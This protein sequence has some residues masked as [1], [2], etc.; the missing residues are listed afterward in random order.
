[1]A[2][3]LIR[4]SEAALNYVGTPFKHLGRSISG[5]DCAGLL[6]LAAKDCGYVAKDTPIYGHQPRDGHMQ[7]TLLKHACRIVDRPPQPDDIVVLSFKEDGPGIHVGIITEHPHGIGC[8]H[9]YGHIG[10]V[11]HQR[12]DEKRMKLISAVLEWKHG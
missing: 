7:A 10:R 11:V 8:V 1:M 3:P 6:L 9:T 4:L 12:L 2:H 5:V